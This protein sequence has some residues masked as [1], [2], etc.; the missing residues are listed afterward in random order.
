[1]VVSNFMFLIAGKA[2]TEE[3]NKHFTQLIC[4]ARKVKDERAKR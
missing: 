2:A 3:N 1:M 4:E